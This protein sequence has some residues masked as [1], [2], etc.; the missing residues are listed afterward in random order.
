MSRFTVREN[1][2]LGLLS[3]QALHISIRVRGCR[4]T[5]HRTLL[6][7]ELGIMQVKGQKSLAFTTSHQKASQ[8]QATWLQRSPKSPHSS[9]SYRQ[10]GHGSRLC[11]G[12]SCSSG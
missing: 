9:S 6:R 5:H 10:R 3:R 8:L 12:R 4:L 2:L 7:D 1:L 11:S